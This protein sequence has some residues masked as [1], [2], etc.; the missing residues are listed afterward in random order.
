MP[1]AWRSAASASHPHAP[2]P[3]RCP[4]RPGHGVEG[5]AKGPRRKRQR[6]KCSGW[7]AAP[8]HQMLMSSPPGP[9][10]HLLLQ[11]RE[12]L[13]ERDR[14]AQMRLAHAGQLRGVL[15]RLGRGHR[16]G[17]CHKQVRRA[18]RR[19]ACRAAP[20][21]RWTRLGAE[22][23]GDTTWHHSLEGILS[24]ICMAAMAGRLSTVL[25]SCEHM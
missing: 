18:Q 9:R 13:G 11:P 15:Q 2:R 3:A 17:L 16:R 10:A 4:P 23:R 5:S 12:R 22:G 24:V 1:G 6:P 14:V 25:S 19:R 7:N 20:R 8:K 21:R